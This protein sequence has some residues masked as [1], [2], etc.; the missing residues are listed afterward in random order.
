MTTTICVVCRQDIISCLIALFEYE[1]MVRM[2][3][4]IVGEC[5]G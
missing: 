2:I 4:Y 3:N 5:S 1:S